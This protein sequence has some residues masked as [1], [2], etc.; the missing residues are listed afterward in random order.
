MKNLAIT[1]GLGL[2]GL[3]AYAAVSVLPANS[4]PQNIT[5]PWTPGVQGGV[6]TQTQGNVVT[7]F[8]A[9]GDGSHD[10]S[11]A[12]IAAL[13]ACPANQYVFVPKPSVAYRLN[14]YIPCTK[15]NTSFRGTNAS[16]TII[17]SFATD[18]KSDFDIS[19]DSLGASVVSIS[20]GY[21]RGSTSIVLGSLPSGIAIGKLIHL[22][23]DFDA[24]IANGSKVEDTTFA[25]INQTVTVTSIAGSTIGFTPPLYVDFRAGLNPKAETWSSTVT[26]FGLV[27]LTINCMAQPVGDGFVVRCFNADSPYV[28]DCVLSNSPHANL[29]AI[30]TFHGTFYGNTMRNHSAYDSNARYG[31]QLANFAGDC[32]VENNIVQGHNLHITCQDGAVGN[33]ISYNFGDI[34]FGNGYPTATDMCYP[35]DHGTLP[36]MNLWE[37]NQL[38]QM[39]CDQ[40]WGTAPTNTFFRNWTT[41]KM[42]KN[43]QQTLMAQGGFNLNMETYAF[44]ENLVGN[45]CSHFTNPQWEG[46]Y[47][48]INQHTSGNP[49]SLANFIHGNMD[50]A[51]NSVAW[52]NGVTTTLPSSYYLSGAPGWFGTMN[53]PPFGPDVTTRANTTNGAVLIPAAFRWVYGVAPTNTAGVA[54]TITVQPAAQNIQVGQTISLNVQATGTAPFNYFWRLGGTFITGA[55]SSAYTKANAQTA[56]SGNYTVIVSN[57]TGTA[58]SSTA[59]VT[60]TNPAVAIPSLSTTNIDFGIVPTNSV[61]TLSFVL[62]NVGTGTLSGTASASAPY[63]I[64]APA[65]G[66]YALAA[67]TSTNVTVQFAPTVSGSNNATITMTGG[68]GTNV[69]AYG[70]AYVIFP[71]NAISMAGAVV[72]LPTAYS[73]GTVLASNNA[74]GLAYYAGYAIVGFNVPTLITNAILSAQVEATNA[75]NNSAW[76]AIDRMPTDPA[77]LWNATVGASGLGVQTV[78]LNSGVTNFFSL[79]AGNHYVAIYAKDAN[80]RIGTMSV[81]IFQGYSV[82]PQITVQPLSYNVQVGTAVTFTIQAVG[83]TPLT[84]QWNFNGLPIQGAN[85]PSYAIQS[86]LPS[87]AGRYSCTVTNIAGSQTSFAAALNEYLPVGNLP[88]NTVLIIRAPG[89]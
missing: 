87:D 8:G 73:A 16:V 30:W 45:I 46:Q 67:S 74:P 10:D 7:S 37:G 64:T 38:S 5:R 23:Q 36:Y 41:L 19:P 83:T 58:T 71:T 57:A 15:N 18:G 11:A 53:F 89:Q 28:V 81:S 54:P 50:L 34:G 72:G 49:A 24:G 12:F 25:V 6:P 33:V 79:G 42:W 68:G 40:F 56:D 63:S 22:K 78:T 62:K 26:N 9:T 17:N 60:V 13:A 66:A 80:E 82:P 59:A 14:H 85:Q 43:P 3:N 55:T 52:S 69:A 86:V 31:I 51:N 21:T 70:L 76:V 77:D 65:G 1:I 44:G 32:L 84:Y 4:V 27:G 20:S 39:S 61:S 29:Q 35:S 75:N 48:N 88:S 47:G 2:L